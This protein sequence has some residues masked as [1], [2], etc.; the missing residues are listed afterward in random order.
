[1]GNRHSVQKQQEALKS[2]HQFREGERGKQSL[3]FVTCVIHFP[4]VIKKHLQRLGAGCTSVK[5]TAGWP[6]WARQH[7]RRRQM[8]THWCSLTICNGGDKDKSPACCPLRKTK[9]QHNN[10][11][12]QELEQTD[13]YLSGVKD[14]PRLTS[15]RPAVAGFECAWPKTTNYINTSLPDGKQ[16]PVA[17]L[18]SNWFTKGREPEATFHLEVFS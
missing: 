3:S 6:V 5:K 9:K 12:G 1:M 14:H 11:V 18:I 7:I 2:E 10:E 17:W 13:L 4:V 8:W 16:A 15:N